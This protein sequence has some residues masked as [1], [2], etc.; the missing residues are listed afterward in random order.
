MPS[1]AECAA[2]SSPA[3]TR[4]ILEFCEIALLLK[5]L[6]TFAALAVAATA[7]AGTRADATGSGP[8]ITH[9]TLAN[10]LANAKRASRVLENVMSGDDLYDSPCPDRSLDFYLGVSGRQE[11][12][13]ESVS[14]AGLGAG[15]SPD[16][17]L[18]LS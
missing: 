2:A 17:V 4:A 15:F 10:G 5:P 11:T 18:H 7:L 16:W 3:T 1:P 6:M 14:L 8:E 12:R 13:R 9:F